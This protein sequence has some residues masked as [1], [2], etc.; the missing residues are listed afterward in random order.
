MIMG[1]ERNKRCKGDLSLNQKD[2]L[3]CV[4]KKNVKDNAKVW[5]L[6]TDSGAQ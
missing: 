3:D 6:N 4:M 1:L 2:A 5:G